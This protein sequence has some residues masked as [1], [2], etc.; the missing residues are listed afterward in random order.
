MIPIEPE[1]SKKR[2]NPARLRVFALQD[3]WSGH[4]FRLILAIDVCGPI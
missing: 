4:F 3:K 2:Q 1:V